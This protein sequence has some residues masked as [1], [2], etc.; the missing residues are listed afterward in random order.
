MVRHVCRKPFLLADEGDGVCETPLGDIGEVPGDS[1]ERPPGDNGLPAAGAGDSSCEGEEEV[2]AGELADG[3]A[4][5]LDFGAGEEEDGGVG[6]VAKVSISTC[7]PWLQCPNVPQMKY[8]F[9]GAVRGMIV[10]PSL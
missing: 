8:R 3:V 5:E 2:G 6:D 4:G 7:I 10:L 9:P 1:V